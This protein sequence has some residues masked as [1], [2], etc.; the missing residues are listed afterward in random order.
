MGNKMDSRLRGYD[1]KNYSGDLLSHSRDGA[2][3]ALAAFCMVSPLYFG[4][5]VKRRRPIADIN[6]ALFTYLSCGKEGQADDY[7]SGAIMSYSIL[8]GKAYAKPRRQTK[9]EARVKSAGDAGDDL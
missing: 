3:A 4:L 5:A 2:V 1:G 8:S 9:R 7:L 6:A